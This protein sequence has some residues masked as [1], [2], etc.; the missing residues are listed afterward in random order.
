MRKRTGGI[1]AGASLAAG[2]AIGIAAGAWA[3]EDVAAQLSRGKRFEVEREG[4]DFMF[5]R[6]T[7]MNACYL[8]VKGGGILQ[9]QCPL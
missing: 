2:M 6:D 8:A 7:R 3:T 5:I 1:V 9:V 4:D